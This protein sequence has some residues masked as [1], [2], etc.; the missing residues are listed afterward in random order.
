MSYELRATS[1]KLREKGTSRNNLV[2]PAKG[3]E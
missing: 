1:R 3:G 2:T